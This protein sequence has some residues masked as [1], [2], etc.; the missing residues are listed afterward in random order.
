MCFYHQNVLSS[1]SILEICLDKKMQCAHQYYTGTFCRGGKAAFIAHVS[2]TLNTFVF[3]NLW[4]GLS[5]SQVM[6]K[7]CRNVQEFVKIGRNLMKDTFL[8][9]EDIRN[10]LR[11]LAKETY[12]KDENDVENVGLREPKHFVLLSRH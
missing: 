1:L 6:A 2:I 4:L 5:I 11:K 12:N 8:C 10:I 7:H 3:G 9:E